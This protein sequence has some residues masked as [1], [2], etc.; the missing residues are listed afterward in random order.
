VN[1]VLVQRHLDY[2]R[3]KAGSILG[4]PASLYRVGLGLAAVNYLDALNLLRTNLHFSYSPIAKK[5]DLETPEHMGTMFYELGID[6]TRQ[7]LLLGDVAVITDPVYGVG[8]T[9]V[10]GATTDMSAVA[11]CGHM[12]GKTVIGARIDRLAWV[13][14]PGAPDAT[15]YWDERPEVATPV[16]LTNGVYSF[17]SVHATPTLVPVGLMTHSRVF[18]HEFKDAPGSTGFTH[19][20][21]YIPPLPGI[22]L[23]EGDYILTDGP[24]FA[25]GSRYVVIGPWEQEEAVVGY[26]L[27]MERETG[28]AS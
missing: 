16:I 14:R 27:I 5:Q 25:T 13:Y 9:I 8:S 2:G 6:M 4:A 15:G 19:Y 20:F 23:R 28:R 12:P 21:C 11:L 18:G 22:K 7:Q 10:E 24:S 26:Q 1:Y 3:G 17:G